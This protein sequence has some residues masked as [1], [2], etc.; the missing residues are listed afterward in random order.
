MSKQTVF[1]VRT[2]RC[3]VVA[4]ALVA[5]AATDVL[6]GFDINVGRN[7]GRGRGGG[8]GNDVGGV[9][10]DAQGMLRNVGAKVDRELLEKWRKRRLS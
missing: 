6:A 8:F 5:L 2:W 7:R 4:L 10:V 1:K 3:A 9:K